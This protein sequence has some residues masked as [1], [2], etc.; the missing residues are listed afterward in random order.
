MEKHHQEINWQAPEF[1]Y[2]YKDVSW[3]WLSVII[4]GLIIL[5]A[6][7]QKNLLF[8]LFAVIA[9]IVIIFWAKERPK[10][11]NFKLD[12]KKVHVDKITAY[13]YEDLEGFHILE[14][15]DFNELILKTK[16]RMHPFIKIIM[17][18]IDISRVR[19]FLKNHLPEIEYE[20][21][22]TDHIHKLLKF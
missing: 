15:D 14:K 9:E 5:T 4:A 21:S 11:L 13:S 8:A 16:S 18:D 17:E 12:N 3:Y 19:D 22:L 7:W 1:H 2:H 6:I 20:E 10:I